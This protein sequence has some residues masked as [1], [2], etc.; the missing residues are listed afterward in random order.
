MG[1]RPD[2]KGTPDLGV[3]EDSTKG[4]KLFSFWPAALRLVVLVLPSG[5]FVERV[6][7]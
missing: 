6:F 4:V 7:S 3:V 2:R 1:R 5:A